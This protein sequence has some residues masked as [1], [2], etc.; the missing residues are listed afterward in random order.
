M[1]LPIP[2][3]RSRLH[4]LGA[5]LAA[6]ALLLSLAPTAGAAKA[7][8]IQSL[9]QIQR[10]GASRIAGQAAQVGQQ[11][12][13][14]AQVD[15]ALEARR[16]P[17]F[18]LIEP[19]I[20]NNQSSTTRPSGDVP[21]PDATPV[22]AG[23]ALSA[24]D[25]INHFQQRFAG[26]GAY[27]N[28]QF[29]LEPPDSNLCV[30]NGFVLEAVNTVIIVRDT[31]GTALTPHM[32]INEF[33]GLAPAIDR[34]TL[35]F[36]PF[37]ADPKCFYDPEVDRWFFTMLVLGVDPPT[38]NFTGKGFVHLAVSQSGDPT[39]AWN[40]YVIDTTNDGT[41]GTPVHNDC[42]CF[43]DQPLIGADDHGFYITTNEFPI[44]VAGFN[45]AM[46]YAM[47]K[48][49]LAA[50][51]T[52]TV[53]SIFQPTLEEGQAYSLQPAFS[54]PGGDFETAN[55][56][57]AYFLSALEFTGRTDDRIAV[58]A[59]TNTSSLAD[60]VPDVEMQVAVV[61][62]QVYGLPPD[63]TQPDGDTPLLDLLGTQLAPAVLGV[64]KT[65]EHLNLIAGNDDRMNQ[66]TYADG[67]L[68]SGLNTAV[69]T[70][71][72]RTRVGIAWFIVEP[73]WSNGTLGGSLANGGYLS[74][75][76]N[77]VLF[78]GVAVNAD[79][80]GALAFTL[81]GPDFYPSAAYA[82]I[83]AGG[84][85]P[86]E[87]IAA[88]QGP[89]DGFTG[90]RSLAPSNAGI[91]RWGDYSTAFAD[92]DGDIWLTTEY[93]GQSCSFAEFLADVNCGGTRT[94]LA[95]WGN[96]VWEIDP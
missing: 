1:P 91:E 96:F 76:R 81:V 38:G 68:W 46:V 13:E 23:S 7:V 16:S 36:G 6:T 61:Q 94:I 70:A 54:P 37:T 50:G 66:T 85:G 87:V 92:E 3:V 93:I 77:H 65:S 35:T 31:A 71:N 32:P 80:E 62:S 34:A 8:G 17:K 72:G 21:R 22:V 57:T 19:N 83:D 52:P 95:N 86:I 42:P 12:A 11:P 27:A 48:D 2:R 40:L 33:L 88:G 43:G 39:G 64:K 90:Y 84:T 29:S 75:N 69:K 55:D 4:R 20:S 15:L 30:G 56:G 60:A 78:P 18:K 28:T 25:G 59:M 89:A 51:G 9:Q 45:G 14:D 44:F 10:A 82:R 49:I 63:A 5:L 58:W 47:S 79:G 26:S 41:G 67:L 24:W 53:V 74:V 73:T